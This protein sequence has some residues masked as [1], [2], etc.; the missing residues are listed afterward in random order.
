M[1]VLYLTDNPTLGGTIRILQ[2]WLPL[3]RE[4]GLEGHVVI[5]PGSDFS[6]WLAANGI[7]HVTN[8]MPWPNRW[9][10]VPA[11]WHAQRLARWARRR[12][13]EMIHCNEHNL[14]PFG[15]LLR[16][17]LGLPLVCHVRYRMSRE[18]CEWAF[19]GPDRQ[20]DGLLWTSRQQ[21][22]D[23]A[24]A[25]QG[26]VPAERQQVVHLGLDPDS[27]GVR[28]AEASRCRRSWGF[29][30]GEVIIGQACGARPRKRLEDFVDLVAELAREDPRVVGVLAGD[31]VAGDEPYREAILRRV[32]DAGLGPRFRWLGNVDATSSRITRR[33]TCSS[34]R[35]STRRSA[36][37]SARRWPARPVVAYQGGS[38]QEVVG[39]AGL[40]VRTG[41]L[42]GLTAAARDVVRDP[43][44]RERLG[45]DARDRVARRF[46]PADSL[47]QLQELYGSLVTGG[48]MSPVVG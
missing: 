13:I 12:R 19:G 25:I 16:R 4:S 18:F 10:P 30:P 2:S 21:E 15:V 42:A 39:D 32:A 43:H 24:E 26:I 47:R 40:V 20:P 3:G 34:A 8:P 36:T 45:R 22:A 9:W 37:A 6:Q 27:F 31:A 46:N 1:R 41:D 17:L 28:T 14:Y 48:R 29:G 11:L 23:C 5:R 7:P 44:L 38:I 35:A 33:S